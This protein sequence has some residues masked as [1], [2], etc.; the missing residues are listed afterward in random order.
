MA[1]TDIP[2]HV[3]LIL[4]GNRRWARERNLNTL[5]GHEEGYQKFKDAL[6]FLF[7]KGVSYV[8]AYIFSTENWKRTKREVNYLMDLAFKMINNDLDELH[9]KNIKVVWL[10]TTEKVSKK[11]INAIHEAE[12]KTKNN[13][14][15]TLGL[16]FNYGGRNEIV[17]AVRDIVSDKIDP[18]DVSE[19]LIS[20]HI[21]GPEIPDIDLMIRS[22]GEYRLSNFML[23]RVAYSELYFIDKYW[24]AVEPDD[25]DEV[26]T[27]Y[28]ERKRR[29]GK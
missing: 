13:D 22:S 5:K 4:D 9:K 29:Y 25:L 16:C 11:L 23:W 28:A 27:D 18:E 26:L 8:S 12:E 17:D 6:D 2:S 15:G 1:D 20:E 7:E 21:Y 14:G 10:G 24:P 3:G 19:K